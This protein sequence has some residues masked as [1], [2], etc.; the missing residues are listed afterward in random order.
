M[1]GGTSGEP[2]SI[3]TSGTLMIRV[4]SCAFLSYPAVPVT[5]KLSFSLTRAS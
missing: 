4:S 5:N 1:V 3:G 2:G